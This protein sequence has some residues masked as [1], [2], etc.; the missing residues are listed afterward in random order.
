MDMIEKKKDGIKD[1]VWTEDSGVPV[2]QD[3]DGG[4]ATP[5]KPTKTKKYASGG[6]VSSRADGIAQRGK[7]RG[8]MC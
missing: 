2:P 4:S 7:T 5:K 8:R 6:S 1:G 3:E